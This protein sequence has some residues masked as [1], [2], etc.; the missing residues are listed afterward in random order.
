MSEV[1][2]AILAGATDVAS[3]LTSLVTSLVPVV[4]GVVATVFVVKKGISIFKSI[5]SK[6]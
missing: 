6:A 4:M 1:Q 3:S 5:T 2:A